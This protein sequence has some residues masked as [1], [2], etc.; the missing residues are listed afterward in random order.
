MVNL[1]SR[2]HVGD[3][4]RIVDTENCLY[5]SNEQMKA[6]HGEIKTIKKVFWDYDNEIYRYYLVKDNG[7]SW[8][9]DDTCFEPVMPDNLPE[10]EHSDMD[11]LDLLGG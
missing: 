8:A 2:Y 6:L 11:V 3:K 10:F 1:D 5:G 4:V 7:G 9:W